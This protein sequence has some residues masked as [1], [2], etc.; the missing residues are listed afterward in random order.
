MFCRPTFG[1]RQHGPRGARVIRPLQRAAFP[2]ILLG[3]FTMPLLTPQ[4][5]EASAPINVAAAAHGGTATAS[6]FYNAGYSPS[7]ANDGNR[8]GDPWGN[9]GG[10]NDA[11]V[12]AWGDWLQITFAGTRLIDRVIVYSLQDAF[13]SPV[14]PSP[15]STFTLYGLTG[16]EV[17]YW[18]GSEWLTVPFGTITNNTFIRRELT[19]PALTTTAI[20][21][22]VMSAL[23]S[24]SR[25]VEVEAFTAP[26]GPVNV[27]AAANGGVA[28]ASSFFNAGYSP[29]GANDGNRSG[30]Q[31]GSGGGWNDATIDAW[32]DWLQITFAGMRHIDRVTV[33]SLRDAF[34]SPGEPSPA[35]TFTLYGLTGFEVQYWTGSQWLTVPGGTITN[36]TLIQREVTFPAL[37]TPAIRIVVTSALASWSRVVEVEA[38]AAPGGPVNVAAAA[39]GGAASASSFFNAGFSPG[40][41]ND[42]NRRGDPWGAGGGWNDGTFNQWNDWWQVT[43]AGPQ[44][45]GEVIVYSLQDAYW[46]PVEPSPTQTFTSY[47]LTDFQIQYWNGAQW[48]PV[49]GGTITGNTLVRRR[50]AFPALTTTAIRIVVT[51]ALASF[52]RLAEVEVYT[53]DVVTPDYTLYGLN[54]SPYIDGQNPNFGA[55]VSAAQIQ[56]RLQII[57]PYTQ[58]VRTFGSTHGL[59]LVPYLARGFGKQVAAG[60]WIGPDLAQ[61]AIEINNL[62]ANAQ[63]GDVD[64]AIVGSEVLLRQDVSAA[65]LLAYINQVRQAIPAGIPV[66]TADTYSVLLAHPAI[67][68][69]SDIVLPNIYGFWEGL[70]LSNAICLVDSAYD[71]LAA[72][73]GGKPIWISEVGWPSDGN[74]VGNAVP[75]LVNANAFFLQFVSWARARNV[76]Y[77]YFSAFS[78]AWKALYEGPVG[79]HWGLWDAQGVL[80]PGMQQ[81]FDDHTVPVS[82][83]SIPG[84]PGDPALQFTD[85]PP[86]GSG[87]TERLQGTALHVLPSNYKVVIYIRVANTWWVKPT[88]AAP[89]TSIFPDGAW[90]AQIMTGGN[91]ALATEIAAFLIPNSYS[92]PLLGNASALPGEL[93]ANAVA[94]AH[95]TRSHT[96]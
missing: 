96:P 29:G 39:N 14:D 51:G 90:S 30:D 31:W 23:A 28:S 64:L 83:N 92:P 33:Y 67:I 58:W 66:A 27:A 72:V 24:W 76:P 86:Y 56:A 84:G 62:I 16:F 60:A 35:S 71:Q 54:F 6:S 4:S 42:G 10:W 15:A 22:V 85:V 12:N 47:G 53:A 89:L 95:V 88:Y 43:F 18:T 34:T 7:G 41:A 38:F 93:Y 70:S 75:S 91:D 13:M 26:D 8:R 1:A 17:Q 5:A 36:N 9:G 74:V 49:P 40:G 37:T 25:V 20:R 82:C 59:E 68:A 44:S 11:T 94:T 78:E 63:A 3:A 61:N 45:I 21:I 46:A 79:A 57:A 69:A 65:Q 81:V 87:S 2:L 50:V 55:V 80:K 19:F 32:G 77:L 52:S 48:F 73:S